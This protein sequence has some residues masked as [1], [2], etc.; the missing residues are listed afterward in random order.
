MDIS[1]PKTLRGLLPA[2]RLY[3]D[4]WSLAD[5][6][7]D[8]RRPPTTAPDWQPS[9]DPEAP[10]APRPPDLEPGEWKMPRVPLQYE[11]AV[12]AGAAVQEKS[13]SASPYGP[14]V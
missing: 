9:A 13:R 10:T 1:D 4:R 3:T 2:Y 12:L 11:T 7:F 8:R 6:T 5:L 14:G